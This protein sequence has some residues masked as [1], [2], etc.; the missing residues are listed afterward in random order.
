MVKLFIIYTALTGT[1]PS[2]YSW[3]FNTLRACEIVAEFAQ[4]PNVKA[5]CVEDKKGG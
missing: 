5:V 4:A 1:Q 2:V 3:E